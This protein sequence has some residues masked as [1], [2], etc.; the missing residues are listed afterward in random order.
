MPGELW[1][2]VLWSFVPDMA[3]TM[4][5]GAP[6]EV[7][8]KAQELH[9]EEMIAE[10]DKHNPGKHGLSVKVLLSPGL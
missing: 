8:M 2:K 9:L 7:R 5:T 3:R 1:Q 4:A 6:E 10:W